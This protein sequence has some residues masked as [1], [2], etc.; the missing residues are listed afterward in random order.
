MHTDTANAIPS[1]GKRVEEE[2]K[3]LKC[4]GA[5]RQACFSLSLKES[6][7]SPESTDR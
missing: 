4:V 1:N 2:P 7:Q 3:L 5:P 6:E